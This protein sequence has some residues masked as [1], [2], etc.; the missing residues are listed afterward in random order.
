MGVFSSKPSSKLVCLGLQNAGKSSILTKI[1]SHLTGKET[2][3]ESMVPTVGQEERVLT[4]EN[5]KLEVYDM[6]GAGRYRGTLWVRY[7]NSVDAIIFVI[8][9]T[10]E[11]R[12]ALVR[13][14]LVC[15]LENADVR[16]VPILFFANKQ[17]LPTALPADQIGAA[18]GMNEI[19]DH[20]VMIVGS[21]AM[22]GDG[23]MDGFKW[24]IDRIDPTVKD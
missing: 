11:L 2:S 19:R 12:L 21:S 15:L 16:N 6:S 9:S 17:D 13:D 23:L 18:I 20:D 5:A 3:I 22:T 10:D 1:N 24:V 8:D 14:E 7:L 4:F